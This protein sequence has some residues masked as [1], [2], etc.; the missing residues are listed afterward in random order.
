MT[1]FHITDHNE[2]LDGTHECDQVCTNTD[3]S[4]I[5]SCNTGYTLDSNGNSCTGKYAIMS[6]CI[7]ELCDFTLSTDDNECL[8]DNGG[9]EHECVN[10]GGSFECHCQNGY[11]LSSDGFNCIGEHSCRI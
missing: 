7:S 2:C 6:T 9:C 1:S 8:I 5:C 3:G 10:I 11:R 4:Y